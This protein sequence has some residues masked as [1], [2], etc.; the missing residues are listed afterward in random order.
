MKKIAIIFHLMAF[1][2]QAIP[3]QSQ[4]AIFCWKTNLTQKKEMIESG[5]GIAVTDKDI[6]VLCD[7]RAG[8]FKFFDIKGN[9]LKVFGRRGEGP[10][11]F[12][13]PRVY[14]Y[15]DSK[16]LINDWRRHKLSVYEIGENLN[17][18][19]I[20]NHLG[21]Y[22]D[23]RLMRNN[24]LLSGTRADQ[25]GVWYRLFIKNVEKNEYN[26][27][28]QYREMFNLPPARKLINQ[29]N[30]WKEL[31]N[32]GVR[33]YCDFYGD[34]IYAV[35][36]GLLS[37]IKIDLEYMTKRRFGFTT[38]NYKR[39]K[40]T[41]AMIRANQERNTE[42]Y[43]R[44]LNNFSM[45]RKI[46]ATKEMIIVIYMNYIDSLSLLVPFIQFYT[47][48]GKFLNEN[49]LPG[50]FHTHRLMPFYFNKET[51]CLYALSVTMDDDFETHYAVIKYRIVR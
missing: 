42:D 41:K 33:M 46:I 27:L 26:L 40:V 13:T 36:E 28:L 43:Y 49:K 11:E 48:E 37:V 19:R 3:V 44:E 22:M 31:S 39:P 50:A 7:G 47:P 14:D 10:D 51:N 30:K 32:I 1:L 20:Q 8:N 9:L 18:K 45:V 24:L 6:I 5:G 17:M 15:I 38:T 34:S 23:A 16:L 21:K 4:N 2:F 25:N 29:E 35:W 12:G